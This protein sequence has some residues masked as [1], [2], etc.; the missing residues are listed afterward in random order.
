MFLPTF[1]KKSNLFRTQS[2]N[3]N[4]KKESHLDSTLHISELKDHSNFYVLKQLFEKPIS[5]DAINSHFCNH[6]DSCKVCN[7]SKQLCLADIQKL[8]EIHKIVQDS[9]KY[10]FQH[11]RIRINDKINVNFMRRML[12]NYYDLEICDLLEFGFPIGFEGKTSDLH[13]KNQIW[14]YKNHKGAVEFPNDIISYITKESSHKAIL[15]PFKNNPFQDT[16][17]ISPLN[18]VPKKDSN[19]R[20]II[21]DLSFPK[22]HAVNDY[23]DKN[24]YLGESTQ[25]IFPKV[26]DL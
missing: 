25:I 16:L 12:K 26:D 9:G 21:M 14:Q 10:N 13:V 7:A 22:G 8:L 24:K 3:S 6:K 18:T 17:I 5:S 15:G 23:V 4:I 2:S 11:C 1:C 20:R 19:D